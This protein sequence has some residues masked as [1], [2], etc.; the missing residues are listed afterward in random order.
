MTRRPPR[1]FAR[2]KREDL[3]VADACL[4]IESADSCT[5]GSLSRTL[6]AADAP[7]L[8]HSPA[9]APY[10]GPNSVPFSAD[11][12]GTTMHACLLQETR[13]DI[14]APIAEPGPA[15]SSFPELPTKSLADTKALALA[16]MRCQILALERG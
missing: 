7:S 4:C 15:T 3:T 1:R 10:P 2:R 12:E 8:V 6:P 11:G 9:V 14:R 5:T 16:T 13:P